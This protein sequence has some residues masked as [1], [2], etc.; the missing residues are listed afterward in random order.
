MHIVTFVALV[1]YA[2]AKVCIPKSSSLASALHVTA[3]VVAYSKC[4]HMP[5]IL[6]LMVLSVEYN[7][8]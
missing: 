3:L 2:R 6:C 1:V 8:M 7:M 5:F 4:K